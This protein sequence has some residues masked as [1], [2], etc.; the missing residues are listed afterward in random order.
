MAVGF[1]GVSNYANTTQGTSTGVVATGDVGGAGVAVLG[2]ISPPSTATYL[3]TE[4]GNR[5]ITESGNY[6]ITEA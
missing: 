4:S 1:G 6:L 5:L 2:S 3:V